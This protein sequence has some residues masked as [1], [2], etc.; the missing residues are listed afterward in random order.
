MTR[1]IGE[2]PIGGVSYT[3]AEAVAAVNA[4]RNHTFNV[5]PGPVLIAGATPQSVL[6][7]PVSVPEDGVYEAVGTLFCTGTNQGTQY[8]I[9]FEVDG[10]AGSPSP[11][12]DVGIANGVYAFGG[13]F[14]PVPL[15]AGPHVFELLVSQPGGGGTLTMSFAYVAVYRTS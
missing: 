4:W 3:D 15:T 5:N 9:D 14:G 13:G 2:H 12:A 1:P 7:I 8:R 10:A 6:V 11:F